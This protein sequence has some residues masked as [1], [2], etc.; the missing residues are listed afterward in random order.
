[1]NGKETPHKGSKITCLQVARHRD[2]LYRPALLHQ[3]K[4]TNRTCRYG[5]A[6]SDLYSRHKSVLMPSERETNSKVSCLSPNSTLK[7]LKRSYLCAQY[8]WQLRALSQSRAED[9]CRIHLVLK[10]PLGEAAWLCGGRGLP[11]WGGQPL[12]P[13]LPKPSFLTGVFSA[14]SVPRSLTT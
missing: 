2:G 5:P 9:D 14:V 11:P 1:M 8:F 7:I 4:E 10:C 3:V 6:S 12:L 13:E